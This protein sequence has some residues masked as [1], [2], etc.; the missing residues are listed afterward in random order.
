MSHPGTFRHPEHRKNVPK[1]RPSCLNMA[2]G[3]GDMKKD[4]SGPTGLK[5]N[6]LKQTP[7]VNALRKYYNFKVPGAYQKTKTPSSQSPSTEPT[8]QIPSDLSHTNTI[9][10]R[11]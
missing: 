4:T 2:D 10:A 11:T 6:I 8:D 3:I 1:P 5:C 9:D 7:P